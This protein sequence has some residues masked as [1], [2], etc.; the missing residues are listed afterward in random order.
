VLA[1]AALA[2]LLAY[3]TH[4][5]TKLAQAPR[6]DAVVV[7]RMV[8][9]EVVTVGGGGGG[10]GGDCPTYTVVVYGAFPAVPYTTH[11]PTKLSQAPE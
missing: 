9:V 5:P 11:A 6:F 10:G 1:G 2:A 4:A 3:T 7:A 8:V